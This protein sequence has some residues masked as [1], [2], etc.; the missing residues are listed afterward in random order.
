MNLRDPRFER[1]VRRRVQEAI[2]ESPSLDKEYRRVRR[3]RRTDAYPV[4]LRAFT[5]TALVVVLIKLGDSGATV[6]AMLGLLTVW[7]ACFA[8]H[9]ANRL[10]HQLYAA[11]PLLVLALQPVPDRDIFLHQWRDYIR[12]SLWLLLD[13]AAALVVI[14][15]FAGANTVQWMTALPC[16]LALWM[17]AVSVATMFVRLRPGGNYG[18]ISS[19]LFLLVMTVVVAGFYQP[20]LVGRMLEGASGPFY[21]VPPFGWISYIIH[22]SVL[23]PALLPLLLLLPIALLAPGLHH[24]RKRLMAHYQFF[25]SDAPELEEDRESEPPPLVPDGPAANRPETA[26][27]PELVAW[28][29][30]AWRDRPSWMG[31][32][33][34]ERWIGRCLNRREKDIGEFMTAGTTDWTLTLRRSAILVLAAVAA[35]IA[36]GPTGLWICYVGLYLAASTGIPLLGT[37]C[38]GFSLVS[39]SGTSMP[40]HAGLPIGYHELGRFL[41]KV[42]LVRTLAFAPLALLAGA[43]VGHFGKSAWLPGLWMAARIVALILC[44]QPVNIVLQVSSGTNDTRSINKRSVA[45]FFTVG[46]LLLGLAG[47]SIA[48]MLMPPAWTALWLAVAALFSWSV[49]RVYGRF[50]HRNQFDLMHGQAQ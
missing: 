11:P 17:G 9:Y 32:G 5:A 50:Y 21:L 13:T 40:A 34:L 27:D 15:H 22:E 45:M 3:S 49:F 1:S 36:L 38:V 20:A 6:A 24:A 25:A 35:A 19:A 33:L 48:T 37:S 16:A 2:R 46:P 10:R 31:Q 7:C 44:W 14:L 42:G 8:I 39:I 23:G 47:A 29:A 4:L 43:V 12:L 41:L 30:A 28:I 26:A 18:A